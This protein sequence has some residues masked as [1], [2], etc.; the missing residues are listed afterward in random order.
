MQAQ[1]SRM[2]NLVEDLMTLSRL[3]NETVEQLR[4][5]IS[6]PFILHALKNEA[7][8]FSAERNHQVE[9]EIDEDLYILG[10]AK[11][12][13]SAFSNLIFN[14]INY[15]RNNAVIKVNWYQDKVAA[16]FSVTDNGIGIPA[17]H[18]PRLTERF[19]RVDVARS[20]NTGGSGLGLAI[21]NNVLLHHEAKLQIK[22][23][24][25]QG[26]TFICVFPSELITAKNEALSNNKLNS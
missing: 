6:V 15:S 4:D 1:S 22:S 14:A 12:L 24:V 10:D 25:G 13:D 8:L 16:Y 11:A 5:V 7:V 2:K 20:R 19:Y 3:E 26:S 21:V 23:V 9:F 18:I 17:Q